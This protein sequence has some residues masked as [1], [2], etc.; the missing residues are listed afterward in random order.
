MLDLRN[1]VK[2]GTLVLEGSNDVLTMVLGTLEHS[3]LDP[4]EFASEHVPPQPT[5]QDPIAFA[6]NHVLTEPTIPDPT[7][8]DRPPDQVHN[9]KYK[10]A[11]GAVDNIVASG[12]VIG[13]TTG[14]VHNVPLGEL[15]YHV[16][17]EISYN[18]FALLSIPNEN[19][20]AT[21]VEHIVGSY[22]AWPKVLVTFN[23]ELVKKHPNPRQAPQPQ[24]PPT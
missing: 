7:L 22:S 24:G 4:I 3:G 16:V 17:V 2:K 10:L 19:F 6:S 13:S 15:N 9:R 5:A 20:V 1:H 11:V 12:Y 14:F 8:F 21:L 18:D 23:D